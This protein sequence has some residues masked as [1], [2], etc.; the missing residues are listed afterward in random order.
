MTIKDENGKNTISAEDG[1]CR[2]LLRSLSPLC[3]RFII[4]IVLP[5]LVFTLLYTLVYLITPHPSPS[6]ILHD[7]ELYAF[8]FSTSTSTL[9]STLK[10]NI[11]C[12]DPGYEPINELE[13]YASY[14]DQPITPP[15]TLSLTDQIEPEVWSIYLVGTEVP[16]TPDLAT[17]LAQDEIAGKVS[18][19]VEVT[20]QLTSMMPTPGIYAQPITDPLEVNCPVH[21]MF[22][23]KNDSNVDGSAVKNPFVQVD[24]CH[25][26]L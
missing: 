8:N 17:L 13:A 2:E 15:T 12:T 20:G 25:D 9:T 11:S 26:D 7:V 19:N 4:V 5:T 24:G 14:K 6:F 21:I 16:L 3:C 1:C 23:N 18:I 10:I 22:G